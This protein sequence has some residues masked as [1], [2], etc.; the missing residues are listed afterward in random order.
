MSTQQQLH[1]AGVTLPWRE[2]KCC[3]CD[4]LFCLSWFGALVGKASWHC[5]SPKCPWEVLGV[6][7]VNTT[8]KYL[9]LQS[10]FTGG[11]SGVAECVLCVLG[12][13][14]TEVD[15]LRHGQWLWFKSRD[16][17]WQSDSPTLHWSNISSLFYIY[18]MQQICG[19]THTLTNNRVS[20]WCWYGVFGWLLAV[21]SC[22]I[23]K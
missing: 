14:C 2:L 8:C 6:W 16:G 12:D 7:R 17:C 15:M 1:S 9:H 22:K 19:T 4:C 11:D 13:L 5:E 18:Q 20:F 23:H 10:V 21:S 3:V